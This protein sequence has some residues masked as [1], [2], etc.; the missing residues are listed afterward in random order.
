MVTNDDNLADDLRCFI[1]H[2]ELRGK[3]LPGLNLRMTEIT[4]AIAY[5]QLQKADEIIA[6]RIALAEELTDAVKDIEGWI[7][8][9]VSG[10]HVFY[11]WAVKVPYRDRV[12]AYL[13]SE[14]VPIRAGYVEPLYRHPAF[15]TDSDCPVAKRLHDKELMVFEVCAWEPNKEQI[16]QIAESFKWASNL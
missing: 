14:G 13:T 4:A 1:N 12:V 10:K 11:H 8:P 5:V 15:K 9:K 16:K 2:G 6:S 3:T 7:P